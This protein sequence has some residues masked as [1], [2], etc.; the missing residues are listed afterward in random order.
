MY[1]LFSCKTLQDSQYGYKG[2]KT[3]KNETWSNY[4]EIV[5][6]I[7]LW[8]WQSTNSI[9]QQ[10]VKV[11]FCF[12]KLEKNAN[13]SVHEDVYCLLTMTFSAYEFIDFTVLHWVYLHIVG[14]L[15]LSCQIG[16]DTNVQ[17]IVTSCN[18]LVS[19]SK[20]LTN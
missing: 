8:I 2:I 13:S 14:L 17:N 19:L 16:G 7:I 20:N 3:N 18:L 4:C 10:N 11:T 6:N 12:I 9:C 5:F 1:T 15:T